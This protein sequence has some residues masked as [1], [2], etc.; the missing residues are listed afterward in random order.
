MR[1]VFFIVDEYD[2]KSLYPMLVKCYHHVHPPVDDENALVEERVIEK[3]ILHIFKMIVSTN[4]SI[5]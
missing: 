3:Y 4:E 2:K 5:T 1:K